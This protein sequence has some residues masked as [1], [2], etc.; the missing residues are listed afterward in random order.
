MLFMLVYYVNWLN[1]YHNIFNTF[2]HAQYKIVNIF[3][4][5]ANIVVNFI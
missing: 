4:S 2:A 3:Y 1:D 5:I